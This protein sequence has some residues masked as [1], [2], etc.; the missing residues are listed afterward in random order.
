[1]RSPSNLNFF[2]IFQD[3]QN[4]LREGDILSFSTELLEQ[5]P[6]VV[7]KMPVTMDIFLYTIHTMKRSSQLSFLLP[8]RIFLTPYRSSPPSRRI[9]LISYP[10]NPRHRSTHTLNDCNP[11]TRSRKSHHKS[12]I[13]K[14]TRFQIQLETITSEMMDHISMESGFRKGFPSY[15]DLNQSTSQSKFK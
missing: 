4:L 5:C 13:E 12:I 3:N 14:S 1:M 11:S 7:R 8:F 15:P 2:V 9:K 6:Y 10:P